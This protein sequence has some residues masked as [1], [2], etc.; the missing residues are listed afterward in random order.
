VAGTGD[1]GGES[2]VTVVLAGTVNLSI[3]AAKLVAGLLSGSAAMLSEAMHSA[4]DTITEVLLFV[5]LR[6][7]GQP[8]DDRHPFGYGKATYFW[9]FIA[10]LFTFVAGGGFAIT[11]GVHSI[12]TGAERGHYLTSYLVLAIAFGLESVSLAQAVRQ[13]R[14]RAAPW[15][16]TV[17][18]YL[19]RTSDTTVKAVAL[20]DSAALVGLVLAALGLLLT[21]LTGLS[22]SDGAASILIGILLVGVAGLL[23]RSNSSLLVGQSVPARLR[24]TIERELVSVPDIERVVTLLT[25]LLGPSSVLVAAKVDFRDE[26]TGADVEAAAEEAERRLR[27]HLPQIDYLFLDPTG[28]R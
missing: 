1:G 28:G 6:R 13:A 5:A 8:A 27:A 22:W 11:E 9:A 10:S 23:A 2:T 17:R 7:G 14:A 3:A 15:R 19:R 25:M 18:R 4:A 24:D 21:Q 16:I 20:E 26:A 12:L